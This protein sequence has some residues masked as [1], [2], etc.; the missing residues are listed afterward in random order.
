MRSGLMKPYWRITLLLI[1]FVLSAILFYIKYS[2]ING[3][4]LTSDRNEICGVGESVRYEFLSSTLSNQI[5]VAILHAGQGTWV[6]K[7][8]PFVC[9]TGEMDFHT[10]EALLKAISLADFYSMPDPITTNWQH[11]I[12]VS[13]ND[14]GESRDVLIDDPA[15][16]TNFNYQ[17]VYTSILTALENIKWRDVK[18]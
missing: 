2:T 9:Q 4:L 18:N 5:K 15:F 6:R 17:L 7:E 11:R 1:F 8:T 14:S 12:S 13:L 3:P 10:W 16:R